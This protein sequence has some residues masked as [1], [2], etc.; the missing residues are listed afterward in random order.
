MSWQDELAALQQ[1]GF[2][3]D[4]PLVDALSSQRL[5]ATVTNDGQVSCKTGIPPHPVTGGM[6][7]C[8][9][10]RRQIGMILDDSFLGIDAG[11]LDTKDRTSESII[12]KSDTIT[13]LTG[14]FNLITVDDDGFTWNGGHLNPAFNAAD[15]HGT[16]LIPEERHVLYVKAPDAL[17]ALKSLAADNPIAKALT[18]VIGMDKLFNTQADLTKDP[19]N[20]FNQFR[21]TGKMADIF[22]L[23]PNPITAAG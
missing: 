8:R 6:L 12:M 23:K 15:P 11:G 13:P 22:R 1:V 20:V 10:D 7:V 17:D 4:G 3:I 5:P 18:D 9:D 14:R 19:L 16:D 2:S 21:N